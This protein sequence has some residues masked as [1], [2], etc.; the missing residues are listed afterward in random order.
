MRMQR[1]ATIEAGK[2]AGLRRVSLLQGMC[3]CVLCMCVCLCVCVCMGMCVSMCMCVSI[4]MCLSKC[5]CVCL[6]VC[7]CACLCMCADGHRCSMQVC[8]Y[9]WACEACK[10]GC[11]WV[12]E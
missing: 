12:G 10:F 8:V 11:G 2:A 7:L 4:C 5:M 3:L 1:A 6:C 9:A